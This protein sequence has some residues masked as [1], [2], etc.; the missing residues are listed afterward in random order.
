MAVPWARPLATALVV[1]SLGLLGACGSDSLLAQAQKDP[2][3]HV[4][5]AHVTDAACA[6]EAARMTGHVVAWIPV[7]QSQ[8]PADLLVFSSGRV[9]QN[10]HVGSVE[11][12]LESPSFGVVVKGAVSRLRWDGGSG[13]LRMEKDPS[14]LA[15]ASLTWVHA[16]TRLN[17]GMIDFG[18]DAE[19]ARDIASLVHYAE[20]RQA[21]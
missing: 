12:S 13:A 5:C 11:V 18:M 1:A 10:L 7:T 2:R 20:V 21:R 19:R 17:L 16:G 9:V 15:L 3:V 4:S 8:E 6:G 14:D